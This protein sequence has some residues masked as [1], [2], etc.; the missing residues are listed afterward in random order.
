MY[1][2]R[3]GVL[4]LTLITAGSAQQRN[5]PTIPRPRSGPAPSSST[6]PS[7]TRP[8]LS[9]SPEG[10]HIRGAWCFSPKAICS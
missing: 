10:Y 7:N 6:R 8:A 5:P 4:L 9:F 2:L 3:S 1:S